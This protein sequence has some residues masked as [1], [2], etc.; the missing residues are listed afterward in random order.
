MTV[1]LEGMEGGVDGRVC[2]K[3]KGVFGGSMFGT[4]FFHASTNPATAAGA[5]E[6]S[7]EN[8]RALMCLARRPLV[9]V[10][11]R[12]NIVYA[13]SALARSESEKI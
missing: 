11:A 7:V 5:E 2:M 1:S 3:D 6:R 8:G 10:T 13:R 9:V 4:T 12:L